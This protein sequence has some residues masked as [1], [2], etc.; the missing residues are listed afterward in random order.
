MNWQLKAYGNDLTIGAFGIINSIA[1]LIVMTIF[2]LTQGMQP[3]VGFN[4]GAKN[5]GRVNQ[6]LRLTIYWASGISIIGFGVCELFPAQ[7]AQAFDNS[8]ELIPLT[9][10]GMRYYFL[11]FFVVGFQI[12]TSNFF[13]SIGKANLAIVLSLSRQV[14]F[15]IP[16][17]LIL[18]HFFAL[19]GVWAAVPL[20]D[21]L[22]ALVTVI[23][24][25]LF[26]RKLNRASEQPSDYSFE[27][28][29]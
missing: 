21:L 29:F 14:L 23:T 7:I 19:N 20:S 6:T 1:G 22:A 28:L 3:I 5:M 9:I 13:Q 4:Y 15:L 27:K 18:P 12:V 24:L 25:V 17:I 11:L 8:G 10:V 16:A 26:Y 2:G